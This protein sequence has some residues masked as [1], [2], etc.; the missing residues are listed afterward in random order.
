M[1]VCKEYDVLD[2][3]ENKQSG[4]TLYALKATGN[5]QIC[6]DD[7][8]LIDTTD[9]SHLQTSIHYYELRKNYE[10]QDAVRS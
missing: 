3:V 4:K 6:E 1:K 2:G 8:E 7:G 10:G 5:Y 9:E